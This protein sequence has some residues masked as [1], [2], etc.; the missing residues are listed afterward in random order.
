MAM[1]VTTRNA[2]YPAFRETLVLAW[3]MALWSEPWPR[4]LEPH[5]QTIRPTLSQQAV[6]Q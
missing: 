4:R 5:R 3:G 2:E 6:S 1:T